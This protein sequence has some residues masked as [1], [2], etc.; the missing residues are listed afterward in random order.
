M[1]TNPHVIEVNQ[2]NFAQE[3][4][5]KS[6][7]LPVIV[8]FWAAWCGP[9]RTLG[10]ILERLAAEFQGAFLLAKLDVDR[11][12][13]LAQQFG[14]QGIPAV[15]AFRHGR[16]VS[17][18]VGAIPEAKVRDFLRPLIPND[19]DRLATQAAAA[20]EQGH[21]ARAEALYL[22][23]LAKQADHPLAILG[24]ARIHLAQGRADQAQ[25][26]LDR[27]PPNSPQAQEGRRLLIRANWR[28]AADR[29]G[30]HLT[31][32]IVQN[33][34]AAPNPDNLRAVISHGLH[35]LSQERYQDGLDLL[36]AAVRADRRFQEG[37][38]RLVMVEVFTVLGDEH[39]L[40]IAYRRQLS[41]ALY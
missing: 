21:G 34:V 30:N 15:K 18:F 25:A 11:N 20:E 23:A 12:Q 31:A 38:A 8:D 32:P 1:A 16:I 36:L 29:F 41:N 3:V 27:L 9:C 37:A 6:K 5:E 2:Q 35:A 13:R 28:T 22:S 26:L 24:L 33:G 10:P 40:T 4:I 17:E 7:S 14:V 19:A 39:P